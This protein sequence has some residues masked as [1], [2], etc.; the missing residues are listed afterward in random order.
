MLLTRSAR[1]APQRVSSLAGS[2]VPRARGKDEP[3]DIVEEWGWGSFPAS[4]PPANW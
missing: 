4:D 3:Q 1:S 2:S